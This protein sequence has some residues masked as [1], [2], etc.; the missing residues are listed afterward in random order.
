MATFQDKFMISL[1]S[2]VLFILVNLPAVYKLVDSFLTISVF[3]GLTGCPTNQGLLIHA[4]VF[5]LI[6]FFSMGNLKANR[7]TKLNHSLVG[8]LLFFFFA[9]PA[10]F[11]FSGRVLG[12]GIADAVGCPTNIGIVLH[13][14]F[15]CLALV[16]FMYLP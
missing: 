6:T 4:L 5:F 13:G 9:N 16:G 3:N 10:T 7:L 15:Y 12:S 2:A 1:G 14:L 8:T 11:A